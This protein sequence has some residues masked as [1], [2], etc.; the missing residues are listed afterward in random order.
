MSDLR[1]DGQVGT[2][3]GGTVLDG[4]TFDI[5]LLDTWLDRFGVCCGS[6][7]VRTQSRSTAARRTPVRCSAFARTARAMA[8]RSTA[9]RS[10]VRAVAGPEASTRVIAPPGWC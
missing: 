4:T 9:G 2:G 5:R 6:A 1:G 7:Q 8:A 3:F 10:T